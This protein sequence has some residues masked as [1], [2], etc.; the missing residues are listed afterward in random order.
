M[1]IAHDK[2]DAEQGKRL[3]LVPKELRTR[4]PTDT[5]RIRP[6]SPLTLP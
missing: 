2:G 5:G 1:F 3:G 4:D 6:A